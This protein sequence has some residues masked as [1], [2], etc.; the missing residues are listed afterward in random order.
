LKRDGKTKNTCKGLSGRV[1]RSYERTE[2]QKEAEDKRN[3]LSKKCWKAKRVLKKSKGRL[4][5]RVWNDWGVGHVAGLEHVVVIEESR[6]TDRSGA[7]EDAL[8]NTVQAKIHRAGFERH[9]MGNNAQMA[10]TS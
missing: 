6:N 2:R 5:K 4:R 1:F 8:Q 3:E 7:N 10:C 9:T